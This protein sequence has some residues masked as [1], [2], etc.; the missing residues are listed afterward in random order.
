MSIRFGFILG[1]LFLL[2]SCAQIEVLSGGDKDIYAP[3]PDLGKMSPTN[4]SVNFQGQEMIIPFNEFFTLNNPGENIVVVPPDFKVKAK[5]KKK[6][7]LLS[8]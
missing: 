2:S 8:W 7:L 5:I 4:G 1:A 6:N 3:Q